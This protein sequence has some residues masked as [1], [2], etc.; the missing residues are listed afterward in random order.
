MNN[1]R[2]DDKDLLSRCLSGDRD[3]RETF[4]RQFSNLVY[5]A[6]GQTLGAK[7]IDFNQFDLE[8]LHNTIFVQLLD[9]D[10]KKLRQYSGKN[11][12]SLATWIKVVTARIV[13]DHLRKKGL[14][15]LS[16]K[17]HR[18]SLDEVLEVASQDT[19]PLR[20]ME[21]DEQIT[22]LERAIQ[23]LP[24]R[25]RLFVRLHFQKDLSVHEV[26]E[27]MDLSTANAYTIKHRVILK[28]RMHVDALLKKGSAA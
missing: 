24:P 21:Q 16:A 1:L 2:D 14:D 28:L 12:C 8:D 15:G 26:C 18:F 13:L 5:Q 20:K 25:D 3:A 22:V 11:Q 7:N 19:D 17:K 10:C 4:V 27:I 6:V 9:A 23:Y